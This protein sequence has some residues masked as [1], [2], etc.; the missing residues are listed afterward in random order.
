M[1][2]KAVARSIAATNSK[3][4][5]SNVDLTVL[6]ILIT[7]PFLLTTM[8]SAFVKKAIGSPPVYSNK[9]DAIF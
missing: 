8:L 7:P 1:E 9:T 4:S 6:T 2:N 5:R 3:L